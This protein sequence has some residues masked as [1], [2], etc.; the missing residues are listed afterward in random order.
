MSFQ[1]QG[2]GPALVLV[3]AFPLDHSMWQ[4]QVEFFS[5]RYRVVTPDVFGFGDSQPPRPWTM[6]EMGDALLALLD[7]LKIEQCTLAGLSMGG[8]IAI[9]FAFAHPRRVERLILADTRARADLLAEKTARNDMISALTKDGISA[10]PDKM[11]P[12]LLAANAPDGVRSRV[13]ESIERA[14][15]EASIHAVTAMRDRIDQTA[16]LGSINCPT[17]VVTGDADAIIKVEDSEKMAAA[18]PGGEIRVVEGTGHLSNLENPSAFN[19]TIEDFFR[20]SG[21]K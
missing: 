5:P 7:Q 10:L 8:Y 4:A 21:P 9:P 3:H 20:I 1:E 19:Q 15:V 18:I 13:R 16:N 17:L 11:I 2:Q 6:A 12:R 14:S